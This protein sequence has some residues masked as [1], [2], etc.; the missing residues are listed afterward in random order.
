MERKK[1]RYK[2]KYQKR[3]SETIRVISREIPLTETDRVTYVYERDKRTD[4]IQE[5]INVSYETWF[6]ASWQTILRYDSTHGYLHQHTRFSLTQERE[7]ITMENVSLAGSYQDWLTWAIKR[8][9]S[10][11]GESIGNDEDAG[12][13]EQG[14]E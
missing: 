6:E 7:A 8:R 14:T 5:V 13:G 1:G 2:T 10:E 3:R 9:L 11:I 12:G 4:A